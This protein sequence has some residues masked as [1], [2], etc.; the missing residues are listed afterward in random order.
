MIWSAWLGGAV[1]AVTSLGESPRADLLG[2]RQTRSGVGRGGRAREERRLSRSPSGSSAASRASRPSRRGRGRGSQHHH[3]GRLLPVRDRDHRHGL[4]RHLPG[5]S[6]NERQTHLSP[7]SAAT[8]RRP[9]G[10]RSAGGTRCCWSTRT[11]RGRAANSGLLGKSASGK[12]K[13]LRALIGLEQAL[14]G[15]IFID[16]PVRGG[17]LLPGRPAFGAMFQAGRA[18]RL[19][20][21]RSEHLPCRWSG[22]TKPPAYAT[23]IVLSKLA[24]VV[25]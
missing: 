11:F 14:A 15:E 23:R 21:R 20:D 24:L 22:W 1:V 6:A 7:L 13:F 19:D 10:S 17:S 9:A 16:G 18:V 25:L 2:E 4:H 5:C 3:H 8:S 12:T